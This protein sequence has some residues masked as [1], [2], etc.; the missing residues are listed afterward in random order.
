M[1]SRR[2]H[3][4][5]SGLVIIWLG[6][7][8]LETATKS[9]FPYATD[10]Q[11][12]S[13]AEL[14]LIHSPSIFADVLTVNENA[15]SITVAPPLLFTALLISTWITSPAVKLSVGLNVATASLTLQVPAMTPDCCPRTTILVDVTVLASIF[16]LNV[17]AMFVLASIF[18]AFATGTDESNVITT[19]STNKLFRT[20]L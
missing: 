6:E 14:R 5:P 18:V 15:F 9:P 4:I 8:K 16:S 10:F 3:S 7:P 11:E 12:L 13:A 20:I 2:V 19:S 1:V 17:S